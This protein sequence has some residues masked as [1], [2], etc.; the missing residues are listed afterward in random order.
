MLQNHHSEGGGSLLGLEIIQ[1]GKSKV[2]EK[3]IQQKMEL[4]EK[5]KRTEG[6][7]LVEDCQPVGLCLNKKASF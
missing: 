6:W 4:G 3:K 7:L 2:G 1:R 5:V